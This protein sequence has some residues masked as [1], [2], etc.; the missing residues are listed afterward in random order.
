MKALLEKDVLLLGP[1]VILLIP[2]YQQGLR[3]NRV[4]H[5]PGWRHVLLDSA[6]PLEAFLRTGTPISTHVSLRPVFSGCTCW[7]RERA[8]LERLISE[9]RL[10]SGTAPWD[11]TG[12]G[13]T[14]KV[15]ALP[16][17]SSPSSQCGK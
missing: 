1:R 16:V 12:Q 13:Q 11:K 3:D 14:R 4:N 2:E 10:P 15:T 9:A 5:H 8:R 6:L 17:S 7:E